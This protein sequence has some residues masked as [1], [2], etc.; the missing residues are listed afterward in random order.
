M[1]G[2]IVRA[3]EVM[4]RPGAGLRIRSGT[5]LPSTV[6]GRFGFVG[7]SNWGPLNQRQEILSRS[8]ISDLYGATNLAGNTFAG[9][10][11]A[12]NG[13]AIQGATVRAGTGGTAGTDP[14][15]DG[16]AA[17]IGSVTLK[18]PGTRAFNYQIR[19]A[20][21]GSANKELVLYEGSVVKETFKFATTGTQIDNLQAVV[22][23]NGEHSSYIKIVKTGSGDLTVANV[24]LKALPPGTNP[25]VDNAAYSN[26][27]TEL[28][29]ANWFTA[30]FDT[31][32][33]A[34]HTIIR[35]WLDDLWMAGKRRVAVV[36][37]P[38]T[39][40][41]ANRKAYAVAH[42]NPDMVLWGNGFTKLGPDG[43]TVVNVDGYLAA[44]R[45][46][47]AYTACRP[48]QQLTHRVIPDA[49]GIIGALTDDQL[50]EA[51]QSGVG[52]F[53]L[54]WR[55]N[56]WIEKGQN[57]LTNPATPPKWAESIS[58]AWSKM[59]RVQARAFLLDDVMG[60]WE[61]MIETSNNTPA[62]R[63]ALKNEAQSVINN[64]I[65]DG[66]LISGVVKEDQTRQPTAAAD[67]AYFVFENLVDADGAEKLILDAV[68]P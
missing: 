53:S 59:R 61:D 3:N 60:A 39:E 34:Q 8:Q 42:N 19:A 26:A 17:N 9:A 31:E 66:T 10:E 55:G 46:A 35:A 21:D 62:G 30:A 5:P 56:V 22:G 50:T 48:N 68:M 43:A 40:T 23:A 51:D 33:N 25:T 58:L 64:Y 54:S 27:L 18:Y 6:R 44:A 38:S 32:D 14:L 67:T 47:G 45:I 28:A 13:G 41:W 63:A 16:A 7:R 12:Y 52:T 65:A 49:T 4:I 57:T 24:A 29:K 15:V 36:G 11:E 37:I 20:I 1:P 2:V